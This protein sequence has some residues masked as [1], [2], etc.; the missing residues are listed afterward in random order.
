MGHTWE[1]GCYGKVMGSFKGQ[2]RDFGLHSDP[3]GDCERMPGYK[4]R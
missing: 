3:N 4:G 2:V 1:Y